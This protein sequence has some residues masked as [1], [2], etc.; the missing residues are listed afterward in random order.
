MPRRLGGG[1]TRR[2]GAT[3]PRA[4]ARPRVRSAPGDRRAAPHARPADAV[5]R[6]LGSHLEHGLTAE[7]AAARLAT[8][9]ANRLPRPER[10]AYVRLAARQF[11]DP[12]SGLLVLAAAVSFAIGEHLEAGVIAAIVVLNAVL[13]FVQELGAERALLALR[14]AVEPVA[15]VVRG[16]HELRIPAHGLVPGDLVVLRE[17]DRVPADGR[18]AQA[19]RLQVDESALTGESAPVGK[20]VA[21]VPPTSPLAERSSMVHA[22]TGITRGRGLAL[23]TATGPETEM[24]SIAALAAAARP[25]ATPLQRRLAGL[26][27]LMVGVGLGLTAALTAGMLARDA[28]LEEAFL[29]GVSVAIAAVPE[30]LAATVTIALAQGARAMTARGAI[31]RRLGAVETLGAATLIATDKTGTLTVNQLRVTD[32]YPC[33]GRSR[34]DVLEAGVLA[35]TATLVDDGDGLRVA[36]DSVDGALLLALRAE[37]GDD[38]RTSSVRSSVLEVPFDPDRK[39]QASVYREPDGF[40]VVVKGAPELLLERG[41]VASELR[42]DLERRLDRW[43]SK[44]LRVLAVAERRVDAAPEEARLDDEVELVGLVALGDPLRPTA[45]ESLHRARDAGIDVAM[46]TGDHPLTATAIAQ[47]LDLAGGEPLTGPELAA[48]DDDA[49]CATVAGRD[50][51]ARVTPADKLRLVRAWQ[52]GGHV[53]AVTGDG[54]NDTPALRQADVGVAMGES[55]TEAAREA[56]DVVL[57]DDDFATIVRAVREG[58][59]IDDNVRTFIAFLLSANFGEVF[60]FVVAVLAGIGVPLTVVQVLVVNLLTDGLPAVAL[61]G[62][63]ASDETMRRPPRAHGSLF[64]RALGSTLVVAGLGVGLTATAAYVAGREL[65]PAAAQT[66]AFATLALAELLLVYAIRSPSVPAWR[67]GRN[68]MLGWSVLASLAVVAAVVYIPALRE[69]FGTVALAARELGLVAVLA[70]LPAAVLEAIKWRRR[71]RPAIR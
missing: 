23:V 22:G 70:V 35:S 3:T 10:P 38:P 6:E 45:R 21:A 24:G 14:S 25:P 29:V 20:Q 56:A 52:S 47:A 43:A 5:A 34:T 69:P 60:L 27:R 8:H 4:T 39:R 7:G 58:R 51:F 31:V 48:L 13:G 28:P 71:R 11:L 30:G 54:V 16:G 65:A 44:G 50:V 26:S 53:V 17:G 37:T 49:L 63:P 67:G 46:L 18:L 68:P 66:M 32:V 57:T 62:D 41:H 40:R 33:P 1:N 59:R 15:S 55:G 64:S 12:L 2:M 61:A 19:E 9:G 42:D 36:G